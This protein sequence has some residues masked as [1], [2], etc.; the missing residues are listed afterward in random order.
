MLYLVNF[1]VNYIFYYL[2][3][4]IIIDFG[5]K[6]WFFIHIS[7]IY[8][9]FAINEMKNQDAMPYKFFT[10]IS[11]S[12]LG[13]IYEQHPSDNRY[14]SKNHAVILQAPNYS[15]KEWRDDTVFRVLDRCFFQITR[16]SALI[17]INLE[18]VTIKEGDLI[19][20]PMMSLVQCIEHSLDIMLNAIFFDPLH[21]KIN[22][23]EDE[24][25][26]L[27]LH[28]NKTEENIIQQYFNLFNSIRYS[29]AM[30]VENTD[31][32]AHSMYNFIHRI[33]NKDN[34]TDILSR[35]HKTYLRFLSLIN[36]YCTENRMLDFYAS[37]LCISTNYLSQLIKKESK[38]PPKYWIDKAVL[39]Q[40]QIRLSDYSL[41]L[42]DITD[43][44]GF[45]DPAQFNHFFTRM[46]SIP[47]GQYR[48]RLLSSSEK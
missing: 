23:E 13:T 48:R 19:Y 39:K 10:D 6:Y 22:T 20:F 40:A 26:G 45:S 14:A 36:Q 46:M 17:E 7:I 33:K 29:S 37:K 16:G 31:L 42:K 44:L 25:L 8:Y 41:N 4:H 47:P 24:N 27:L 3:H 35:S 32:L 11:I 21:T 5:K 28:L 34:N 30:T 15:V 43:Q 1:L 9:N 2:F 38:M 18:P 12:L